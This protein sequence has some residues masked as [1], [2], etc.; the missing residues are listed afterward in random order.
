MSDF[1]T[2]INI[3]D[4]G[5]VVISAQNLSNIHATADMIRK[6]TEG[7]KEDEE[8]TGLVTRKEAF[9]VFVE[10]LPGIQAL[11]HT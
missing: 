11:L 4:N 7:F 3:E 5:D 9:G 8:I 6:L 1:G 2:E 10:V